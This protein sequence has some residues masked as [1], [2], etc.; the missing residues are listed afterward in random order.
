MKRT[1]ISKVKAVFRF[2]NGMIAVTDQMG[3]QVA[4]LQGMDTP[5]LRR[6]INKRLEPDTELNG[7][8]NETKHNTRTTKET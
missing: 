3:Q 1:N 5:K 6:K 7:Y 4:E 8:L 2:P